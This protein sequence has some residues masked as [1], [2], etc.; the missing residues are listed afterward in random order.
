MHLTYIV[1]R[2]N[3]IVEVFIIDTK[4]ACSSDQ[5]ITLLDVGSHT[6]DMVL[7]GHSEPVKTS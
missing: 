7:R 4:F 6:S 5:T 3:K 2:S 1:K